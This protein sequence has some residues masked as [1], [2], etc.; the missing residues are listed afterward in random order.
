MQ[1]RGEYAT[2]NGDLVFSAFPH[3]LYIMAVKVN[4]KTDMIDDDESLNT[5]TRI[6]L[7]PT[8]FTEKNE[9]YPDA[10][11]DVLEGCGFHH[12]YLDT[13]GRTFEEA[14]IKLALKVWR[15]YG[16]LGKPEV[17]DP[18]W[19]SDDFSRKSQRVMKGEH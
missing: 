4:P 10:P 16:D 7:E 9:R 6:W 11:Y 13:C 3:N 17:D 1:Y 15:L 14:I 2:L 5:K 19:F 18:A 8:A 12:G